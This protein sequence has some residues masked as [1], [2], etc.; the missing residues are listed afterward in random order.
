MRY[1]RRGKLKSMSTFDI[2]LLVLFA[3]G[4]YKGFKNGILIEITSLV[5]L[6]LGFYGA[7]HLAAFTAR[8]LHDQFQWNPENLYLIAMGLSFVAIV[9]AVY[10]FGK[11][12]T[13]IASMILLGGINKILGGLFGG[14]KIV[15]ILC[16]VLTYGQSYFNLLDWLPE[17]IFEESIAKEPILNIGYY[18]IEEVFISDNLSRIKALFSTQ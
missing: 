8:I 10:L 5:A 14:I 7:Q 12:L 9:I 11:A 17:S 2:A 4:F 13:K 6:L 15:L 3:F 16:L 18:L 1:L